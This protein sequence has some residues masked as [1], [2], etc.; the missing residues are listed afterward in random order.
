MEIAV[1]HEN[2]QPFIYT[3][4]SP[5][6]TVAFSN[7]YSSVEW[8]K[9]TSKHTKSRVFVRRSSIDSGEDLFQETLFKF[10]NGSEEP[11]I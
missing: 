11:Q 10:N 1:N 8:A 7:V 6:R 5:T 2:P 4:T 9:E 3:C